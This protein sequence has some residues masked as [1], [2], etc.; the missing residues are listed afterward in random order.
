MS[1]LPLHSIESSVVENEV[2]IMEL[3]SAPV[4]ST[5]VSKCTSHDPVLSQVYDCN[6][7]DWSEPA[8]MD[9]QLNH[10][11]YEMLN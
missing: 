8:T 9:G 10:I 11:L 1:Q 2:L 4:T 5:V 7:K 6:M 3:V